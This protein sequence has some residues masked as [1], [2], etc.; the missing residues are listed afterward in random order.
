MKLIVL[1]KRAKN[2]LILTNQKAH[3]TL[4]PFHPLTK[5]IQLKALPLR[6]KRTLELGMKAFK[7]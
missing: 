2:I 7:Y 5:D 1:A 3:Q 6:N 4:K